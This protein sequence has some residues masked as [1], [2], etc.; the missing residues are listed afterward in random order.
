MSWNLY[1]STEIRDHL[2]FICGQE[3][4]GRRLSKMAYWQLSGRPWTLDLQ[5]TKTT[6][7]TRYQAIWWS[8]NARV[9]CWNMEAGLFTRKWLMLSACHYLVQR[10]DML[11]SLTTIHK[12]TAVGIFIVTHY[13]RYCTTSCSLNITIVSDFPCT[14]SHNWCCDAAMTLINPCLT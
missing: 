1:G 7:F 12:T 9:F 10:P 11:L 2:R 5:N 6:T 3:V 4:S 13:L 14:V 8:S